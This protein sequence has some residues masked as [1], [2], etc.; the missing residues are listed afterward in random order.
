VFHCRGHTKSRITVT[1]FAE[2]TAIPHLIHNVLA[3][4]PALAPLHPL[5]AVYFPTQLAAGAAPA[6]PLP[7]SLTVDDVN[8]LLM[9]DT[10]REWRAPPTLRGLKVS[11][12]PLLFIK[13]SPALSLYLR[14]ECNPMVGIRARIRANRTYTQFRRYT[15][16]RQI[17]DPSCTIH[18]CRTSAP[19]YLDTIEH[20]LLS[21]P[22]HHVARQHLQAG[23]ALHHPNPPA[24]TLAFISGEVSEPTKPSPPQHKLALALLQLTAAYLDQVSTDRQTDPALRT[25]HFNE[26]VERAPD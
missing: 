1:N 18:A 21:C 10:H 7:T 24:L 2:S 16:L 26:Q 13:T 5:T 22:R 8:S 15:T 23:V 11:T 6:P 17:P 19:F 20:I 4:L 3:H 12:A 14:A 9:A 25:L